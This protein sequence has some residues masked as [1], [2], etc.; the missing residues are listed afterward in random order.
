MEAKSG[1]AARRTR[2]SIVV[3]AVTLLALTIPATSNASG[4][5]PTAVNDA[6]TV[7]ENSSLQPPAPGVLANDTDPENDPLTAAVVTPPA[8]GLLTLNSNGSFTYQPNL[9]FSGTDQFTYVANDGTS[10]SNT[11]TVTITVTPLNHA[12]IAQDQSV[13]TPEDTGLLI[14]LHAT[15]ADN[16]PLTYAVASGVSH[17][18]LSCNTAGGCG[19]TPTAGFVGAD[20]F[21]FTANDGQVD[22]NAATV[23]ITVSKVN[24]PP[25]ATNISLSTP[26]ATAT[27]IQ[28]GA[29]DP[30]GDPLT[31][32]VVTP[33]AHGGVTGCAPTGAC[34]YTP[35]ANYVGADSFTFQATDNGTP[36]LSSNAAMVSIMV[37][38]QAPVAGAFTFSTPFNV[39]LPVPAPGVLGLPTSDPNHDQMTASVAAMPSHG[40]LTMNSDGAFTYAPAHQFKGT[41]TFSYIATDSH[42]AKSAPATVTITVDIQGGTGPIDYVGTDGPDN[43]G[44]VSS[45][46]R[47]A[48]IDLGGGSDTYGVYFGAL[49][50]LV[51]VADTGTT[52]LDTLNTYGTNGSDSIVVNGPNITDGAQRI[53]YSGIEYL[54][55]NGQGGNDSIVLGPG[56]FAGVR[57][58]T[59]NGGGGSDSLV[60]QAGNRPAFLRGNT[61]TVAGW[62]PITLSGIDT[63]T[64]NSTATPN[65]IS[66][67]GY[68][69]FASDGGVFTFGNAKFYGSTGGLALHAPVIQMVRTPTSR[70]YWL[71]A[72]D[73]GV[74]SFGDARFY[75]STGGLALHAPIIQMIATPSGHGYWLLGSDGGV[76]SF[77]DARFYGS[78][79]GLALHAPVVQMVPTL[80]GHGYWLRASDGGI[81]TYGDARFYGSTGA[82][83][84]SVPIIQMV[85]SPTGAGY[86][87]L[88]AN[89]AVF[90]YGAAGF[91]GAT[92]TL[93]VS[94]PT[95]QLVPTPTGNGYWLLHAD[96][97]VFAFGDAGYYGS[98][99]G[100]HI[101]APIVQMIA[102]PSGH[103]YWLLGSD[104]GIFTF[105]DAHF[106]GSTGGLH[107]HQPVLRMTISG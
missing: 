88:A 12:P 77:G 87:L 7:A 15:D 24:H 81:F 26:E 82:M 22:S 54:S 49:H 53:N 86:W 94:A 105:G 44:L 90:G 91:H 20:S 3:V 6:Y 85:Q 52:G 9:N 65:A 76:F 25:V 83:S 58:I 43:F 96:G 71:L 92:N 27:P 42:G 79:G 57:G 63:V 5:P 36:P 46:P 69:L 55:V 21:T 103:G 95:V 62:P 19:Y 98:M 39:T 37:T 56:S 78:T 100:H 11:A 28:L 2:R 1:R 51:Q 80:D 59:I 16:N 93:S 73:G 33:P 89:G 4:A 66:S 50:G 14:A 29:T 38:N 23:S 30:D 13:S 106:L 41:D 74:F 48:H 64:I 35:N 70:G 60:V 75:G 45:S 84:L 8:N 61:L 107:L 97:S 47:G 72:S 104:G 101:D 102:T 10:N 68:W 67:D 34:T 99:I 17:G 32:S 31:F 18:A 40:T